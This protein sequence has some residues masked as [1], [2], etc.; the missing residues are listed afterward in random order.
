MERKERRGREGGRS[1]WGRT[2]RIFREKKA[3]K[4]SKKQTLREKPDRGARA[5]ACTHTYTST[6]TFIRIRVREENEDTKENSGRIGSKETGAK[7]ELDCRLAM[8]PPTFVVSCAFSCP[9]EE[10]EE[11]DGVSRE[12]KRSREWRKKQ[13]FR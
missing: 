8:E 7:T 3:R 10:E 5:H 13:S 4:K 1:K 12:E 6:P 9:K 2:R 11:E